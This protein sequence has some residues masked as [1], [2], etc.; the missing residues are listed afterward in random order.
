MLVSDSLRI[1]S[2]ILAIAF[3]GGMIAFSG[4]ELP[5]DILLL[6]MLL[7]GLVALIRPTDLL[8]PLWAFAIGYLFFRRYGPL[9]F[10]HWEGWIFV[11][12]LIWLVWMF[13]GLA[14]ALASPRANYDDLSG[15][16]INKALVIV[17]AAIIGVILL[18]DSW[19][20]AGL[21]DWEHAALG[22][23]IVGY[24]LVASFCP[25][26]IRSTSSSYFR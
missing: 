25:P 8:A 13:A 4:V 3:G 23:L 15:G 7:C 11:V 21:G 6:A 2:A 16:R 12:P 22:V 18:W 26:L 19:M 1:A 10:L 9:T 14:L 20:S 24:L 17:S 5:Q